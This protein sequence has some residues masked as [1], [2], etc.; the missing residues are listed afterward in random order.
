MKT[1]VPDTI[2]ELGLQDEFKAYQKA[3]SL[4]GHFIPFL[5]AYGSAFS[6]NLTILATEYIQGAKF[7]ANLH[8]DAKDAAIKA[9][10]LFHQT[11]MKHGDISAN[12]Q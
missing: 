11:G 6:N 7:D 2:E 8:S 5:L 4:Q 9:L 12:S 10:S 3:Q 1:A